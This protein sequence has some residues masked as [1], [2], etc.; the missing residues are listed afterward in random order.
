[1]F[2]Q[3]FKLEQSIDIDLTEYSSIG[4]NSLIFLIEIK[5]L[6][7]KVWNRVAEGILNLAHIVE[8][9]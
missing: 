9:Q 6:M 8:C 7:N 4:Q 1:M 3:N 5:Y 2:K